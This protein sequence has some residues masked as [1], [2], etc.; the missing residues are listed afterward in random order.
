[1]YTCIMLYFSFQFKSVKLLDYTDCCSNWNTVI[2]Q[3][4]VATY[5]CYLITLH[6]QQGE[7]MTKCCHFMLKLPVHVF[8]TQH[9]MS[10]SR[11]W[12]TYTHTH[13]GIAIATKVCAIVEHLHTDVLIVHKQWKAWWLKSVYACELVLCCGLD[14]GSPS[15]IV[16]H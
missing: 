16:G 12:H 9:Q 7:V 11:K 13:D 1:M 5:P 4:L 8:M 2:L 10:L 3:I 14:D 15:T 6:Y